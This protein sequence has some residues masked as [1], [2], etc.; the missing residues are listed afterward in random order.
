VVGV[1]VSVTVGGNW[2]TEMVVLACAVPPD[3]VA[4]M[5]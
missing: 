3:P 4:V 1:K 5:V 2:F